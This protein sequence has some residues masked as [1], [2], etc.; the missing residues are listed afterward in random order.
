MEDKVLTHAAVN[1]PEINELMN[2][3]GTDLVINPRNLYME[4]YGCQ[5]NIADSEVVVSILKPHGFTLTDTYEQA[6]VIFINTCAIRDKA[7]QTVRKRLAQFH[8]IKRNKPDMI[9]GVLGCMA[10]RLK[11]TLLEE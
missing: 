4:S 1:Q 9:I 8:E 5:M 6:D 7:E 11:K 2:E 10:E 3:A